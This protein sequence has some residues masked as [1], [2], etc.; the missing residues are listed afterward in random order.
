MEMIDIDAEE[1]VQLAACPPVPNPALPG[2]IE[3]SVQSAVISA[4]SKPVNI[5]V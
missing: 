5:L 2:P 1:G 3:A 4:V